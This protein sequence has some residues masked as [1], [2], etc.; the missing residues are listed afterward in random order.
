MHGRIGEL[1][2][3]SVEVLL[4]QTDD[5]RQRAARMVRRICTQ[6]EC[7]GAD[8]TDVNHR[9]DLAYAAYCLEMLGLA[10]VDSGAREEEGDE[11]MT[12]PRQATR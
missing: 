8:C 4:Q 12:V 5:E 9:R 11:R 7:G 3:L 10:D 2:D 6:H 1:G